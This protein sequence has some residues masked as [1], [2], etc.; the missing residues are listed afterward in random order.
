[1]SYRILHIPS[2]T[3]LRHTTANQKDLLVVRLSDYP[4]YENDNEQ[5]AYMA[6]DTLVTDWLSSYI[7]LEEELIS[8]LDRQAGWYDTASTRIRTKAEFE[9]IKVI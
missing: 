9:I 4:I 5:E 8:F 7:V 3:L 1:M 6:I 2:G